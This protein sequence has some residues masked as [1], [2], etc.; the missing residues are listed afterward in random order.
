ML[1]GRWLGTMAALSSVLPLALVI[2]RTAQLD[3][4]SEA[5]SKQTLSSQYNTL[6]VNRRMHSAATGISSVQNY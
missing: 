5:K 1:L 6:L 3:P 2:P 4:S